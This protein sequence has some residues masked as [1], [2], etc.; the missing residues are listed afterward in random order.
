MGRRGVASWAAVKELTT[1]NRRQI[2][3]MIA[4]DMLKTMNP[5]EGFLGGRDPL[6]I[7]S[8]TSAKLHAVVKGLTPAQL[9]K[10]VNRDKWSIHEII[11]HLA[12][13]ELMF[14]SRCRLIA[15]ED[16]PQLVPFD[17]DR[18]INARLLE[19]ESTADALASFDSLRKSQIRLYKASGKLMSRTGTHPERGELSLRETFETCGGH[20]VNHIGQLEGLRTAL[21][22]KPKSKSK[23]K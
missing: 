6:K 7:M 17:Q 9:K 1:I 12:D 4:N 2:R 15:F 20:D 18:W 14:A 16:H 21:K 23:K 3:F 5:Y 22:A 10:R 8:G 11:V 19:R 13:C